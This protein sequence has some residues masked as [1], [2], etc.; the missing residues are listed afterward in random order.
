MKI[1]MK[2][3]KVLIE[4]V[5]EVQSDLIIAP[6]VADKRPQ[7]GK[8]IAVGE[9][10]LKPNGEREVLDLMVGEVVM[11]V[12]YAPSEM[13]VDGVVYLVIDYKDVLGVEE[14]P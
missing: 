7:R 10:E 5:K 11:F 6:D 12:P 8:V 3:G 2:N 4:K 1:E 9:G 13:K 14:A